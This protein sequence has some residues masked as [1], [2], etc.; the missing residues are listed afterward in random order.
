[1]GSILII[2]SRAFMYVTLSR[3]CYVLLVKHVSVLSANVFA[4]AS[5][6]YVLGIVIALVREE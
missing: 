6:V 4:A 2:I 3:L 5:I 1:M